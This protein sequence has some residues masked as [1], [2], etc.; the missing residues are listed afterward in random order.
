M[1]QKYGYEQKCPLFRSLTEEEV[2]E[3]KQHARDYY[4]LGTPID[5]LWHP[6]YREEC[7]RMNEEAG[8]KPSEK[9]E[10]L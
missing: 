10:S 5:E 1:K 6:V 8:L 3:F 7:Q 4:N 2:E 9:G